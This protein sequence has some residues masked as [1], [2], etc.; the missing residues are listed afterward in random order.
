MARRPLLTEE[1]QKE[2]DMI[3]SMSYEEDIEWMK[4]LPPIP[5]GKT[6]E[7]Y[8][9]YYPKPSVKNFRKWRCVMPLSS[10][11]VTSGVMEMTYLA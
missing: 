10:A 11:F 9:E 6:V 7:D 2:L 3:R 1:Q 5:E 8:I 4:Q